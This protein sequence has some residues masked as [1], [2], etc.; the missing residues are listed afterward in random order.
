MFYYYMSSLQAF[1]AGAFDQ[2]EKTVG[3]TVSKTEVGLPFTTTG[4]DAWL[5]LFSSTSV[6]PQGLYMLCVQCLF[7]NT[8]SESGLF[9]LG[10]TSSATATEPLVGTAGLSRIVPAQ[11]NFTCPFTS[12]VGFQSPKF[13]YY[14]QTPGVTINQLSWTAVKLE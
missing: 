3:L 4:A 10:V 8:I 1:Y 6:L 2:S 5:P 7:D 13:L 12:S 11:I 9:G 14:S